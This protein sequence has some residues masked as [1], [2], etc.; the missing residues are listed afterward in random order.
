MWETESIPLLANNSETLSFFL[1]SQVPKPWWQRAGATALSVY[2]P[3]TELLNLWR[4]RTL[5]HL[6]I[7]SAI[8]L[9][10]G[11]NFEE[12]ERST[13]EIWCA[14]FHPFHPKAWQIFEKF[15]L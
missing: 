5:T 12:D 10:R 13:R 1:S 6:S 3:P 15:G 9:A 14:R 4:V 8:N 2:K 7:V 11:K